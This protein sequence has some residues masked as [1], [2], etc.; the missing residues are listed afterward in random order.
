MTFFILGSHPELSIAELKAVLRREYRPVFVSESVVVI[1]P[2]DRNLSDL[3]ERLAG[4]VKVGRVAGEL[5][6]WNKIEAADLVASLASNA[7]GKN[8]ISFGLS[9]YDLGNKKTTR[10]LE[11]DLDQLGLEVKKRLKE[12][13]RPVRYV[14]GKEPR[15][16]S[17]IVET[18]GLLESGGEYVL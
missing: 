9:V 13:E 17:A 16:S 4:I 12:T 11:R 7:A 10:F 8:K 18:N 14:K 5:K 15:L 2:V 3:Q 6:V 1:E